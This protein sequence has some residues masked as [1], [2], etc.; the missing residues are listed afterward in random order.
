MNYKNTTMLLLG[1][2]ALGLSAI[3]SAATLTADTGWTEFNFDGTGSLWSDT[4][5]FTI[6]Q[7]STLTVTDAFQAGDIFEVFSGVTSLGFTSNPTGSGD[8]IFDDYDAAAASPV[9]STGVW[10]FLAG[11]YTISGLVSESP[12]GSGG[13]AL[14]L[15]TDVSAVPI[16]AA[17]FLFAPA[18][19]GFMGLRRKAKNTV[20]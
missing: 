8:Q 13:A 18:L 10:T 2:L 4:F 17:A 3:S 6:T 7:A 20:A 11:S 12:F 16:P 9:W 5:D 15:D 1:T 14:R 19:L